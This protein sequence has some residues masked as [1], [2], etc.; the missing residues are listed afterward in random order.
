MHHDPNTERQL[1]AFLH[2]LAGYRDEAADIYNAMANGYD[3]FAATWDETFAGDAIEHLLQVCQEN[4]PLRPVVLDAGCG[5][6]RRIPDLIT[7]LDPSELHAL[8]ISLPMLETA[9]RKIFTQPVNFVHGNIANIPFANNSFDV[10]FASWVL[11]TM[12]NPGKAVQEFL[13]VLKPG[14][15]IAY[16]FAQLPDSKDDVSESEIGSLVES[17]QYLSHALNSD[18]MPYHAC[19]HSTLKQFHEGIISTVTLG[20]CCRVESRYL[21]A[22]I[23]LPFR[24][25]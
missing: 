14:G 9:R 8:D 6:G 3:Q 2:L 5:T 22:Q 24:G 12:G 21:P 23:D 17:A 11:E 16:T 19:K 10:V 1:L 7:Y 18:R 13:R 25:N 4:A 20:K 15:I